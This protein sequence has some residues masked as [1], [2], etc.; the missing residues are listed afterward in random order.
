MFIPGVLITILTFPGVIVH[1]AAHQL[2]CRLFRVA[3]LEVCYFRPGKLAGFVIHEPPRL[4][5]YQIWIGVGPFLVNTIL[6]AIIAAP[7]AIPVWLFQ[8]GDI[9]DGVLSWLGV[10]IAMHAFPSIGDA[11]SILRM[12]Q[13]RETSLL[14]KAVAFPIVLFIYLGAMGSFI[15]LNLLYGMIVAMAVPRIAISLLA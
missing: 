11:Q 3:V 4:P 2:F 14:T 1:E 9:L 13:S 6:G 12:L 7:A 15:W 10:S 8:A 5:S